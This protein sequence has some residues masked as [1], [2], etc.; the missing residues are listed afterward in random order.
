MAFCTNCGSPIP[1]GAGFC[2]ECGA[3]QAGGPGFSRSPRLSRGSGGKS[4]LILALAILAVVAVGVVVLFLT[5]VLGGPKGPAGTWNLD[6]PYNSDGDT[7]VLVL[8]KDGNGY[9]KEIVYY[10]SWVETY[11]YPLTWTE[12]GMALNLE[13]DREY[14]AFTWNKSELR[15]RIDGD[16]YRFIPNNTP[17]PDRDNK[18]PPAGTY[19]FSRAY[20][21]TEDYTDSFRK[22]VVD[23]SLIISKD[24]SALAQTFYETI[25]LRYDRHFFYET[26]E[27][28]YFYYTYR[29]GVIT[30]FEDEICIEF[31]RNR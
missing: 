16:S 23:A 6:M 12:S 13:G 15:T 3:K 29:D 8:E 2:T 11:F 26:Q 5:G 21:P 10:S 25:N 9:L 28:T 30:L 4:S 20:S 18:T 24:G 1:N 17:D 7:Y 19:R 14:D 27:D 31:T 22:D